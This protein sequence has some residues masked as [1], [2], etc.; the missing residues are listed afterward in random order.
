MGEMGINALKANLSNPARTYNWEV[1]IPNPKG[2][3]AGTET[4]LARCQSTSQP[5]RS[6][7]QIHVPFKQTGG[8]VY[9]GKMTFDH[10]WE[11]SF[12]EGE[13][14]AIFKELYAWHEKVMSAKNGVGAGAPDEYATDIY[15][16]LLNSKGGVDMEIKFSGAY[17]QDVARNELSY[18]SEGHLMQPVTFAYDYWETVGQ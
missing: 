18:D 5:S 4:L 11:C 7:G 6:V 2:G 1:M 9:P 15:L 12:V 14:R 8:K 16:R 13:D 10:V 3:V 17:V